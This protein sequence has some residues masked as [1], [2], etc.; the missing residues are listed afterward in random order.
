M[1][2][3]DGDLSCTDLYNAPHLRRADFSMTSIQSASRFND[4]NDNWSSL[5]L[6]EELP[7]S[8]GS[9]V[10]RSMYLH[11][12][13]LIFLIC[14]KRYKNASLAGVQSELYIYILIKAIS[15]VLC[16]QQRPNER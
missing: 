5:A 13:S 16:T 10:L 1:S 12:L 3:D 2:S 11:A 15:I 4:D 8:L 14:N 7:L 9:F 6:D